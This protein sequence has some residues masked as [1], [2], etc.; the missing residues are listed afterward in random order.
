[1]D[2]DK[3]DHSLCAAAFIVIITVIGKGLKDF[4]KSNAE[5]VVFY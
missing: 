3:R 2:G 5:I 1:M 4:Y